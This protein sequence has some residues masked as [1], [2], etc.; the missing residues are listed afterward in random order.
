MMSKSIKQFVFF[1]VIAFAVLFLVS[2]DSY[3][4]DLFDHMDSAWF[5][6]CGKAWMN[7]MIPYVDFADSK[8]PLLWLIYGIGYLLSPHNYIGVFWLSVLLYAS[9]FF[10]VFKTAGIF[11]EKEWQA[12]VVA[13]LMMSSYLT[14]WFHYETMAEDWNNGFIA[15]AFYRMCLFLYTDKGKR[16]RSVLL[17][18]FLLG[19]CIAATLLI[20]FNAT[21]MLGLVYCYFLFAL[22]R[23]HQNIFISSLSFLGGVAVVFLPMGI[24]MVSV[25]CLSAFVQEYF[26]HTVQTV[27]SSEGMIVSYFREWLIMTYEARYAVLF[28]ISVI[29]ALMM[30]GRVNRYKWF[31]LFSFIVFYALAIRNTS[32]KHC[33]YLCICLFFPVWFC[34][35]LLSKATQK[36][37]C[38]W[39]GIVTVM[40]GYTLVANLFHWGYLVPNFFLHPNTENRDA[41]YRVAYM[42]SQVDKPATI[43]YKTREI[44]LGMLAGSLP[45]TKYWAEQLGATDDMLQSQENSLRSGNS[46][47]VITSEKCILGNDSI[48]K[49]SGYHYVCDYDYGEERYL[50]YSKRQLQNPPKSFYVRNI[51]VL[52]KKNLFNK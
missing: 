10:C 26:I 24:Y 30:S 41:Y 46:D 2:P 49:V 40:C 35:G 22:I 27:S 9:I 43:C 39:Q 12:Y 4:H 20:K 52:S 25:G 7:G 34:I 37:K 21:V 8:G 48:I 18:C 17:T 31:F 23:E 50:I 29:G 6:M 5:F 1:F 36:D 3:T 19:L 38:L 14:F 42:M 45:G 33:H 28:A 11:L 51:D 47:F 32:P 15:L 13:L 16:N 44:G